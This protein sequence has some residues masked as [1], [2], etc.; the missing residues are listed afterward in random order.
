M[1][2]VLK[3]SVTVVTM[4]TYCIKSVVDSID[5]GCPGD[6]HGLGDYLEGQCHCCYYGNILFN[7]FVDSIDTA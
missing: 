2:I 5:T 7:S 6:C 3:A 4:V 1:E